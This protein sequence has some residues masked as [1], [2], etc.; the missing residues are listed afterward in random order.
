MWG[1]EDHEERKARGEEGLSR[2]RRTEKIPLS[3]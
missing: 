2:S 1:E 3:S